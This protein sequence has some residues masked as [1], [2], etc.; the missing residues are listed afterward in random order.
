MD[1]LISLYSEGVKST[2]LYAPSR[3]PPLALDK[4]CPRAVSSISNMVISAFGGSSFFGLQILLPT[5]GNHLKMGIMKDSKMEC[6]TLLAL[7][8]HG[9]I[10]RGYLLVLYRF[11]IPSEV[12]TRTRYTSSF[13]VQ[14]VDHIPSNH[15]RLL[16]NHCCPCFST[17]ISD[18]DAAQGNN[19]AAQKPPQ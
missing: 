13:E 6:V 3:W 12:F 15:V 19:I 18:Q 2:A 17:E 10:A 7:Q 11:Y 5:S 16:T 8:C 9:P 14:Q 4:L 1:S